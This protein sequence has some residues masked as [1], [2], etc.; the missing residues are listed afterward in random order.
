[1]HQNVEVETF[2][3]E[4]GK[5]QAALP[6]CMGLGNSSGAEPKLD[7]FHQYILG[8][9]IRIQ[10]KLLSNTEERQR[11]LPKPDTLA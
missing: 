3:E 11:A 2:L 7:E 6:R 4:E 5:L 9:G 10:A 8:I 1:M